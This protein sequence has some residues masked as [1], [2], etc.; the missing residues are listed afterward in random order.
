MSFV[1]RWEESKRGSRKAEEPR[2]ANGRR[3]VGFRRFSVVDGGVTPENRVRGRRREVADGTVGE[4]EV[5]AARVPRAET[6]VD[7][8]VIVGGQVVPRPGQT[9]L[10]RAVRLAVLPIVDQA[11]DVAG[12]VGRFV[13]DEIRAVVA[14]RPVVRRRRG[15]VA[16]AEP[17]DRDVFFADEELVAR[18]VRDAGHRV[19]RLPTTERVVLALR[20][21]ERAALVRL[22]VFVADFGNAD[23]IMA[24]VVR[25]GR[26]AVLRTVGVGRGDDGVIRAGPRA[27]AAPLRR[28]N[29]VDFRRS[30]APRRADHIR[31]GREALFLF[32]GQRNAGPVRAGV[33]K[34]L[35]E[36]NEAAVAGLVFAEAVVERLLFR[37]R[38]NQAPKGRAVPSDAGR[39]ETA[40]SVVEVVDREPH[41]LHIVRA[42]HS[43][44]RFA[45]RLNGGQEQTDQNPDDG[46]DDEEFDKRK[47]ASIKTLSIPLFAGLG[48]HSVTF[49]TKNK[50]TNGGCDKIERAKNR[51]KYNNR[52]ASRLTA[53]ETFLAF[54]NVN[55]S[56]FRGRERAR[57]KK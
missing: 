39:R 26:L 15:R 57:P 50:E 5:R 2:S 49:P 10:Q 12:R 35:A 36:R 7:R 54:S 13:P 42:L 21:A 3:S 4:K 24:V 16:D 28:V 47:A 46:D 29:V 6:A 20:A 19:A 38:V 14:L 44:R 53:F 11:T 8:R 17:V 25:R 51:D 23:V 55:L 40:A 48:S 31:N 45:S 34:I 18:P 9:V 56:T 43:A 27:R 22:T 52:N 32:F 41:L 30:G 1:G 33:P 37:E